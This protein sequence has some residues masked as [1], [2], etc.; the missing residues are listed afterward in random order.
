[1]E[2]LARPSHR[3]ALWRALA[4]FAVVG[5]F[6][7]PV[8]GAQSG[9]ITFAGT[10]GSGGTVAQESAALVSSLGGGPALTFSSRTL[11]GFG[12]PSATNAVVVGGAR[13]W[14]KPAGGFFGYSDQSMAYGFNGL[15]S[16]V[17][18]LTLG[19]AAGTLSLNSAL[20]G[21]FANTSPQSS[22]VN[23]YITYQFFNDDY[24][25]STAKATTLATTPFVPVS[26]MFAAN[27]WGSTIRLQFSETN[28]AGTSG[29]GFDGANDVGIQNLSYTVST[30]PTNV[31]PEPSTYL[32]MLTG[33]AGLFVLQ[34]RRARSAP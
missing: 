19:A 4:L 32:L 6:S 21:G 23:R 22:A 3:P 27:G 33:I 18:E 16:S 13:F 28:A 12:G 26:E 8:L 25:L 10:P 29:V 2:L 9:V 20:F 1:M 15:E 34:R 7:A 5:T 31:V 17:L 14:T 30:V 24:S 11:T